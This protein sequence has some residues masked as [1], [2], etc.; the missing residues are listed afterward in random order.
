M[1][2]LESFIGWVVATEFSRVGPGRL[3]GALENKTSLGVAVLPPET[4]I[5]LNRL[6]LKENSISQVR[7]PLLQSRLCPAKPLASSVHK[8]RKLS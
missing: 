7:N 6:N 4:P 1:R 3:G 2:G 5:C 8:L